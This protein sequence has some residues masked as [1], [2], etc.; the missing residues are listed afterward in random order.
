MHCYACRTDPALRAAVC[1]QFDEPADALELCPKGLDVAAAN[2]RDLKAK[3]LGPYRQF[4][5]RAEAKEAERPAPPSAETPEQPPR[6]PE[7]AAAN[8]VICTTCEHYVKESD[9]CRKMSCGC[10]GRHRSRVKSV[11]CPVGKWV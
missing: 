4:V 1:R 10:S 9:K 5:A 8:F 3:K 11:I 6:T 2:D 7:E